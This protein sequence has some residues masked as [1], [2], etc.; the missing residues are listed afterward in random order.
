MIKT[1]WQTQ[2]NILWLGQA[3]MMAMMGMSL[4]YWPL[5]IAALGEFT[6]LE[7]RYW[8]AAIYLAP[9]LTSMIS[10][11]LWGK[12]GDKQGYKRM[13]VRAAF[14]FCLTQALILMVSNVTLIFL[15]R[16]LQGLLAG[17]ITAAQSFALTIGPNEQRSSIIG[18]LQAATAIG[19][20]V[21][22]FLGGVIATFASYQAI[23]SSSVYISFAMILLF[24][25]F[26]EADENKK[27]SKKESVPFSIKHFMQ[28]LLFII[29]LIQIARA[30]ITPI[31]ALFVTEKLG[32]ND[33]T[34]GT[35]YAA[36]GLM[37][38]LSAPLW[39]KYFDYLTNQNKDPSPLLILIL[40]ASALLQALHTLADS[41]TM[42]FI[43]RLLWGICLGA[44]LPVLLRLLVDNDKTNQHGMTLGIGNSATKLGNL[45]GILLGALIEAHFGY[46]ISFLMNAFLYIIA[47]YFM[48]MKVERVPLEQSTSG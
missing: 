18:K 4:P 19:N 5:Y 25:L 32:G 34:V 40:F 37:I 16:L 48:L 1:S 21:G 38:F 43:L 8:S 23:F 9:F 30:A 2:I 7:V 11:P 31:F 17:F 15:I 45:L 47:A 14:G 3:I 27:V 10:V 26:L 24:M 28:W 6:P 39:G 44:L 41:A 13:I 35:L 12:M 42:I 22:P 33:M 29:V 36:T 46:T 20:L